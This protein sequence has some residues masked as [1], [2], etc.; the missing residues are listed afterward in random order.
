MRKHHPSCID[1]CQGLAGIDLLSG[2]ALDHVPRVGL[3]EVHGKAFSMFAKLARAGGAA[4]WIH[5]TPGG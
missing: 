4:E 2:I 5:Q 3:S 1:I